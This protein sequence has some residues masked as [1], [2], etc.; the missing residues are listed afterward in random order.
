MTPEHLG[1]APVLV[2]RADAPLGTAL[3]LHGQ[4]ADAATHAKELA[5][6]AGAGWNAVG[7]DAPEHGRRFHDGRDAKWQAD[8]EGCLEAH[9]E[10]A[11]AEIP[12]VLDACESRGL[13]GPFAVIGVSLGAFTTWRAMARDSRLQIAVPILGSPALPGQDAPDPGPWRGRRVLAQNAEHDEVVPLGP[14]RALLAQIGGTLHILE[15]SPHLVPEVQWW[16]AW[17]RTLAWLNGNR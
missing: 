6:L 8:P 10:E 13:H 1:P 4:Y 2:A 16:G 5:L 17:G 11:S 15:G 9:L 12:A 7:V 14:T 3:V